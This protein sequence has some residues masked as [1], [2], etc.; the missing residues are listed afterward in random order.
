MIGVVIKKRKRRLIGIVIKRQE[1]IFDVRAADRGFYMSVTVIGRKAKTCAQLDTMAEEEV[2]DVRSPWSSGS[3]LDDIQLAPPIRRMREHDRIPSRRQEVNRFEDRCL[4]GVVP[5]DEQ[6][7]AGQIGQ[8]VLVESTIAF[9]CKCANHAT[10]S[11]LSRAFTLPSM[12]QRLTRPAISCAVAGVGQTDSPFISHQ[13]AWNTRCVRC[14]T[15]L[16]SKAVSVLTALLLHVL[17]VLAPAFPPVRSVRMPACRPRA[18]GDGLP[19][20]PVFGRG[21]LRRTVAPPVFAWLVRPG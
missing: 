14:P 2:G 18:F 16:P 19:T 7:D 4:A 20:L 6:I 21:C 12:S 11:S 8:F 17:R 9:Q 1:S 3:R 5:A 15:R 10:V 13:V